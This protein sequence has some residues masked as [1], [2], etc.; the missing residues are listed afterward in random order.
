LLHITR[1]AL[2]RF[3][4][5]TV[6]PFVLAITEFVL[7]ATLAAESAVDQGLPQGWLI[8]FSLWAGSICLVVWAVRVQVFNRDHFVESL[9][10]LVDHH[11]SS[12]RH[13]GISSAILAL[14]AVVLAITHDL[15]QN[16]GIATHL[17][18]ALILAIPIAVGIRRQDRERR[19]I[20]IHLDRQEL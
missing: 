15:W 9:H 8:A 14:V 6:F 4:A 16:V 10:A 11:R 2:G 1:A 20:R 7:F 18:L 17:A 12:L 13:D 3:L 5:N 19:E